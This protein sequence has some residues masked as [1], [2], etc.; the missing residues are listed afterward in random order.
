MNG[1]VSATESPAPPPAEPARPVGLAD[2]IPTIDLVRG[3]ALLGILLMNI[4]YFGQSPALE[5]EPFRHPG[6]LDYYVHLVVQ[7]GFEGKMRGLFSMLFGAGILIFTGRKEDAGL[8]SAD[9]LQRRLLWMLLFG[10]IHEYVFLWV[11]DILFDYAV[12]G[13]AMYVFRKLPPRKL[14]LAALVCVSITMAK[15]YRQHYENP[16]KTGEIPHRRFARKQ[17]KEVDR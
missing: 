11:G 4:P 10:V 14:L 15:N 17:E 7:I 3:M 9:L 6:T 12:A 16:R 2:R 13:L 5:H 1:L 8:G